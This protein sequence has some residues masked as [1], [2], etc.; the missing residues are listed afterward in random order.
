M[1]N[2]MWKL[3][4]G[5]LIQTTD[6]TRSRYKTRISATIIEQLKQLSIQHHSHIG[7]L[8]ENGYVNMLLQGAITY[9]KKNRPKDRIEFRTT[10]DAELLEHLRDFAKRQQLNLNDVIEASVAYINV[11]DVK[12]AHYRYR[13]VRG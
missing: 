5:R 12:D 11:E 4:N 9:D 6:E 7:Y 2:G 10:C 1:M 8:L 3:V 13:I